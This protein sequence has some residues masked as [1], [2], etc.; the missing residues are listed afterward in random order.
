MRCFALV[1]LLCGCVKNVEVR[2]AERRAVQLLTFTPERETLSINELA[3]TLEAEGDV[4]RTPRV[5]A[6]GETPLLSAE[7]ADVFLAGDEAGTQGFEVDNAILLEVFGEDGA[8]LARAAVG[9]VN[10]LAEGNENIDL[11]S[12]RSF[13]FDA[14][15]VNLRGLVPAEGRFKL[16][17]TVLDTGGVGRVTD[18]FVIISPRT[19]SSDEL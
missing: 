5:V 19:Q 17:A 2:P 10:G 13:R 3:L 8:R 11:R 9:Y 1:L 18:V 15:E 7:Q 16:R 14:N 4:E 6:T 12:D